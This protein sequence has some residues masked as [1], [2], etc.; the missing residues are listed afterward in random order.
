VFKT[1]FDRENIKVFLATNAEKALYLTAKHKDIKIVI[2]D[3]YM[4][5]S[6]LDGR[7]LAMILMERE[8]R[9]V[10][11]AVTGYSNKFSIDDCLRIG[12]KDYF[13]KP[14]NLS[15]VLQSVR[16]ACRRIRRWEAIQ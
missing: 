7:T 12:F 6:C 5:K 8:P 1:L 14:V 2:T 15:V 13:V 10:V 11:F 3:L 4:P 9:T 16:C